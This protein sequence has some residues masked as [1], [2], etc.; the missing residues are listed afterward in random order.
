MARRASSAAD[1]SVTSGGP[2][3]PAGPAEVRGG[4]SRGT[5]Q[6]ILDVALDLF[7]EKGFDKTSLRE[8]AERL[9]F[10]KA[11]LYYHFASKDDILMSLHLRLHEALH[12]G[13][14][15]LGRGKFTMETWATA[16]DSLIDK[17]PANRKLIALHERNRAAFEGMHIEGHSR[18]HQDIDELLRNA[19][20]DP[21]I[22]LR[23]R[24]RVACAFAAVM[25][26]LIFS[27]D[28]FNDMAPE[29]LVEELKGAVHDLLG[30][31]GTSGKG[32]LGASVKRQISTSR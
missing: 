15:Q 5:R 14:E 30:G 8:L 22:P 32:H 6:R 9:G 4:E 23:Q 21:S 10:S 2:R 24:V 1:L 26:G 25:G 27:G 3:V 17:F 29:E 16:L 18:D 13:L 20:A 7:A 31:L 28:A 11:A 19:L 12:G